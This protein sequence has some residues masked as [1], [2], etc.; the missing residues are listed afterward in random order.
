MSKS[1]DEFSVTLTRKEIGLVLACLESIIKSNVFIILHK[2][3]NNIIT[4]VR[5][6]M[7]PLK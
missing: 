2:E 1:T 3:L 6:N 7:E 5:K 4:K